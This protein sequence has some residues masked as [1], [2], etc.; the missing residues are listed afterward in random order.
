[1]GL[2]RQFP[3]VTGE[4]V[5]WAMIGSHWSAET[6]GNLESESLLRGVCLF[7]QL[8]IASKKP[9]VTRQRE[10]ILGLFTQPYRGTHSAE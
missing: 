10:V 1:M 5:F 8:T 4:V 7:H 2:L 6:E 3:A 9:T